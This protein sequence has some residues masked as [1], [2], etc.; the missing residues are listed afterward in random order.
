MNQSIPVMN[1]KTLAMKVRNIYLSILLLISFVAYGQQQ[2]TGTVKLRG[3]KLTYPLIRKWIA[4]FSKEYPGIKVSIA[5]GAPADSIDFRIASYVLTEKDLGKDQH[6]VEVSRY[7]QLPVAN[8]ARPDLAELQVKGFTDKN[9]SDLFFN[10]KTPEF[11]ESSSSPIPVTLYVRDRPVCAVKAFAHHFGNDPEAL[12]GTGI[13][14]DDD[15]LAGAVRN[16]INGLSFNNL[17]FIYDVKTRKITEGLAVIPLDLNENG[18]VDGDEAIYATLDDVLNFIERTN[19]PKFVNEPVNFI[20]NKGSSNVNAG[21]F[22]DWV[23]SKGQEYQHD[24]GFVSVKQQVL[25]SERA[26][27]NASFKTSAPSCE[28]ADD[29]VRKRKLKHSNK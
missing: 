12:K 17:G 11:M 19:H 6:G 29:L 9:L 3:T 27:A 15:D 4:E 2:E 25:S 10:A 18:K 21:I 16:D 1:S 22:L 5:Q 23:L 7:V 26:V 13:K 20:F 8:I 14:G 24:L 28:S